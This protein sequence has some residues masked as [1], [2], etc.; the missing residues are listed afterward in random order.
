[1]CK[2]SLYIDHIRHLKLGPRFGCVFVELRWV[3]SMTINATL[4]AF[5]CVELYQVSVSPAQSRPEVTELA[6]SLVTIAEP[7]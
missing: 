5:E 7:R 6:V 3:E 1:M 2:F 4:I